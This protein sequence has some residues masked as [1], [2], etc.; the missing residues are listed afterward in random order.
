[1]WNEGCKGGKQTDRTST[2]NL[3]IPMSRSHY[4]NPSGGRVF[5]DGPE[6]FVAALRAH[7]QQSPLPV[8]DLHLDEVWFPKGRVPAADSHVVR[9]TDEES[10]LHP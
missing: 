2:F 7:R 5:V 1:M 9:R 6:A 3:R 8:M 4:S 10:V